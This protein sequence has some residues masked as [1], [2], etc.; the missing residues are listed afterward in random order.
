MAT[1]L[2]TA[3]VVAVEEDQVIQEPWVITVV[4]EDSRLQGLLD[5]EVRVLQMFDSSTET[6]VQ[7]YTSVSLLYL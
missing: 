4:K 2:R 7:S 1:D 5:N 6:A 3:A